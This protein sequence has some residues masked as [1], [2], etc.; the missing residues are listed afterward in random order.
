MGV[1][2]KN[3][4]NLSFIAIFKPLEKSSWDDQIGVD[5]LS[6]PKELVVGLISI[7]DVASQYLCLQITVLVLEVDITQWMTIVGVEA[8]YNS[9]C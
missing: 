7:N 1:F 5:T 4:R 8:I 2:K 3:C 9:G 6:R